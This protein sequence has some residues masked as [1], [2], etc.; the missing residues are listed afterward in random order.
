MI[1]KIKQNKNQLILLAIVFIYYFMIHLTANFLSGDDQGFMAVLHNQNLFEWLIK[2]YQT[3]SSRLIIELILVILL[4][5]PIYVWMI[6]DSLMFVLIYYSILKIADVK[7]NL[8]ISIFLMLVMFFMPLQLFSNAGWGATTL[9]Y[10]WPLAFGMYA[11]SKIKDFYLDKP[12]SYIYIYIIALLIGSNQEQMCA[13]LFGFCLIYNV[14]YYLE[15]KKI[16]KRLLLTLIFLVVMLLFIFL[17]P[18]NA[19]RKLSEINSWYPGFVNFNYPKQL[20]LGILSTLST[21]INSTNASIYVFLLLL[22]LIGYKNKENKKLFLISIIPLLV[23]AI[24]KNCLIGLVNN[25]V[26]DIIKLSLSPFDNFRFCLTKSFVL[27]AL[28]LIACA[29][30]IVYVLYNTLDRRLFIEVMIILLAALASRIIIGF[31]PTVYAS[32]NRTFVFMYYLIIL[33][34]VL[35]IKEVINKD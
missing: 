9:N 8:L 29:I 24:F 22:V 31:S 6:L 27:Y 4:N 1:E 34:D 16:N 3:W 30:S 33:V 17:C 32:N 35:L 20:L 12:N 19:L 11:L 25:P 10:L 2:R 21:V 14:V 28:I 15:N 18:G 23:L 13:L 5:L 26:G 7:D